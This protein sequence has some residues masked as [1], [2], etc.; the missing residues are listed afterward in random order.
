MD[1]AGDVITYSIT[2]QNTGNTTLDGGIGERPAAEQRGLRRDSGAPYV[3]TGLHH[4]SGRSLTC[5]GS[6]TVTQADIDN[7]GGGDGDLDNIATADSNET[8]PDTDDE[9]GPARPH[10]ES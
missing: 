3:N 4:R 6:Y 7:N 9:N 5:T 8:G 2:V 10:S 1:A